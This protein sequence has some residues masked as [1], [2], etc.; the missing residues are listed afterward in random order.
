MDN[1]WIWGLL[2]LTIL[3]VALYLIKTWNESNIY[4][5]I[6]IVAA[7]IFIMIILISGA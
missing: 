7:G 2:A 5:K 6:I 3:C 4:Q 1:W